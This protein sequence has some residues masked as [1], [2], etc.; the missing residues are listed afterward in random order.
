METALASTHGFMR[1]E[2]TKRPVV[3]KILRN[4]GNGSDG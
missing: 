3:P 4:C 1:C 2:V